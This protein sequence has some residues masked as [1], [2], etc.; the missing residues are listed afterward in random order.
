MAAKRGSSPRTARHIAA[1]FRDNPH[2]DCFKTEIHERDAFAAMFS[3]GGTVAGMDPDLVNGL[4]R[5]LNNIEAFRA[6][7]TAKL[8]T[9]REGQEGRA[10]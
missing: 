8:R 1:Q 5:A 10:A 3:I 6:E 2:I 7:V 4:D 9:I